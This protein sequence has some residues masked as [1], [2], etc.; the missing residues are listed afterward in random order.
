MPKH[1]ATTAHPCLRPLRDQ[2]VASQKMTCLSFMIA[3]C[4]RAWPSGEAPVPQVGKGRRVREPNGPAVPS[5]RLARPVGTRGRVTW[6][7]TT[8]GPKCSTNLRLCGPIQP[9][10][11]SWTACTSTTSRTNGSIGERIRLTRIAAEMTTVNRC[12]LRC[13]STWRCRTIRNGTVNAGQSSWRLTTLGTMFRYRLHHH[14]RYCHPGRPQP[15]PRCHLHPLPRRSCHRTCPCQ[16]RHHIC[17]GRVLRLR[18]VHC[19]GRRR[20]HLISR[21]CHSCC[22]L[23]RCHRPDRRQLTPCRRTCG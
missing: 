18:L 23:Q 1:N 8:R 4:G 21:S 15:R 5:D 12:E 6:C 16:P 17:H 2:C 22:L 7:S 3:H 13:G 20:H 11:S 10:I 19:R 14:H 9:S